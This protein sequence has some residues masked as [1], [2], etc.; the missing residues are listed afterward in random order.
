[1][2]IG[3]V[4]KVLVTALASL[5]VG[6][7]L[8]RRR[9]DIDPQVRHRGLRSSGAVVMVMFWMWAIRLL[10]LPEWL[11]RP[12][13]P[14]LSFG[15]ALTCVWVG[16]RVVDVIG[17]YIAGNRDLRLT[18]M[19]ELLVPMLTKVLR[20]VVLVIVI[21]FILKYW[22]GTAPTAVLGALGIGGVALAFAAQGTLGNF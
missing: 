19:D 13:A 9:I 4:I 7:W 12:L 5:L 21:L 15:L 8:R 20:F 11:L 22:F 14:I 17:G 18:E 3:W 2:G 6:L 1:M 16:Y 10:D